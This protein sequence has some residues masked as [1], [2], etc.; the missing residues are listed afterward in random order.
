MIKFIVRKFRTQKNSAGK[1]RTNKL[2]KFRVWKIPDIFQTNTV[3]SDKVPDTKISEHILYIFR[4]NKNGQI[5][6]VKISGHTMT[7]RLDKFTCI[8]F[9]IRNLC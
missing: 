2:D 5:P 6:D 4:T 1:F 7:T 3:N 9:N 8:N